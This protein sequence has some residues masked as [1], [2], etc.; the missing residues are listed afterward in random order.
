MGY[1][2]FI[3]YGVVRSFQHK[4]W[5]QNETNTNGMLGNKIGKN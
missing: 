4:M 5:T 2:K 3:A 1:T